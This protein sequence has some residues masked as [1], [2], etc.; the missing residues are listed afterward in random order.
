VKT[1]QENNKSLGN[2]NAALLYCY[3]LSIVQKVWF[4]YVKICK[5]RIE[6]LPSIKYVFRC[7]LP[8]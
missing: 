8:R 1:V 4:N 3:Y 6:T 2:A 7:V 5:L